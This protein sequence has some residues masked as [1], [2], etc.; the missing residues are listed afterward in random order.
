MTVFQ[1]L[2]GCVYSKVCKVTS[3]YIDVCSEIMEIQDQPVEVAEQQRE[4][5]EGK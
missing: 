5:G 1:E 4:R 3:F 2:I